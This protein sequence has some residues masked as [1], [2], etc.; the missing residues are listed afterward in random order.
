MCF[1]NRR[2]R[3]RTSGGLG[4][5]RGQPRLLPDSN[6]VI[7]LMFGLA[8]VFKRTSDTARVHYVTLSQVCIPRETQDFHKRRSSV[9]RC[10]KAESFC[11]GCS[12]GLSQNG[13]ADVGITVF[14][15][16]P[17][18]CRLVTCHSA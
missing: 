14:M 11:H 13:Y 9:Q 6:V 1:L 2:M 10:M 18:L 4:G 17:R 7:L 16:T 8:Q 5:R 15:P 3:N 12:E